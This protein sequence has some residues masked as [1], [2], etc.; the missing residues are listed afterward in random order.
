MKG[1]TIQTV[2]FVRADGALTDTQT[3]DKDR[4]RRLATWLKTTYLN[5]LFL[6]EAS[7]FPQDDGPPGP[8]APLFSNPPP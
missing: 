6:G 2:S 7:F 8:G 4:R 5:E 1:Q 3:L